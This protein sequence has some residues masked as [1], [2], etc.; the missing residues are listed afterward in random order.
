MNIGT[1]TSKTKTYSPRL[2]KCPWIGMTCF[3]KRSKLK[4]F[5]NVIWTNS[6]VKG[7]ALAGRSII[8]GALMILN[9]NINVHTINARSFMG[10]KD[11]LTSI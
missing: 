5:M 1:S 11:L 2:I 10:R 9:V 7:T 4:V 3:V 8:G 6:K